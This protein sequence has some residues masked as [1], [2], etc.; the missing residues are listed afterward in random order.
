MGDG[1]VGCC[2][3]PE[4]EQSP[5]P[6]HDIEDIE[7]QIKQFL[8]LRRMDGLVVVIGL[9]HDA[10][11]THEKDTEQIDAFEA[12]ERYETVI[13][14]SHPTPPSSC[15][16]RPSINAGVPYDS[17]TSLSVLT[18]SSVNSVSPSLR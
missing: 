18:S 5:Q 4:M 11:F 6:F 17:A 14:D 8:H 13:Y 12:T 9:R 1:A 3:V 15:S 7:R 2:S 16:P 10:A